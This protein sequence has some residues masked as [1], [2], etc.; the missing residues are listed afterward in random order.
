MG[1][2]GAFRLFAA[3]SLALCSGCAT[4]GTWMQT[5]DERARI[6]LAINR[7]ELLP[8]SP[9]VLAALHTAQ[10]MPR[11]LT[12][13]IEG[14]GASWPRPSVP[15]PDPT[16]GNPLSL[17]LAIAQV[18]SSIDTAEAVA[19]LGRPCQYLSLSDLANCPTSWWT[20]GRFGELPLSLMNARL[21]ELKAHTP[22]AVLRL[23]GYSGGGA[24]AALLAA[25]R[26]DVTCLVT[27]AA[28]LDTK[29]WTLAKNVSTLSESQ[30]PLDVAG[31]LRDVPMTHFSGTHDSVVPTG[32]NQKFL[33][34][35]RTSE[36]RQRGFDHDAQWLNAWPTLAKS[37]CLTN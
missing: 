13:F 12:V 14:D 6:T 22:G 23:V 25:Q 1:H 34:L 21:D 7:F 4:H 10:A 35:A 30:N 37:T 33:A 20:L 32:I 28:P 3:I 5:P 18:N 27:V 9:Q 31:K 29:A 2:A 24:A 15:P 11:R 16:P 36:Q 26:N 19:Y 8:A 17:L